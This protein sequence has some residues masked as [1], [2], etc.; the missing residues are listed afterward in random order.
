MSS[1]GAEALGTVVNVVVVEHEPKPKK[2]ST[3]LAIVAV[4]GLPFQPKPIFQ[5]PSNS[6]TL[7]PASTG[8][9]TRVVQSFDTSSSFGSSS[10]RSTMF[11]PSQPA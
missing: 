7:T 1:I 9:T 10:D 5:D 2:P 11:S 8:A 3:F 4:G 6:I